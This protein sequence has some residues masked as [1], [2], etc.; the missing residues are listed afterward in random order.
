MLKLWL[1]DLTEPLVPKVLYDDAIAIGKQGPGE[2]PRQLAKFLAKMSTEN[3]RII[4]KLSEFLKRMDVRKTHMNH[5]NLAIVFAPCFLRHDDINVFMANR[6]F[7]M[8]FTRRVIVYAGGED[9]NYTTSSRTTPL[10]TPTP[11]PTPAAAAAAA[12]ASSALT[13]APAVVNGMLQVPVETPEL[14]PF[15]AEAT[16][17]SLNSKLPSS[18]EL[19]R[20]PTTAV[21]TPTLVVLRRERSQSARDAAEQAYAAE[22]EARLAAEVAEELAAAEE[23]AVSDE[24]QQ[25]EALIHTL[26]RSTSRGSRSRNSTLDFDADASAPAAAA[27]THSFAQEMGEQ[28][29]RSFVS[30]CQALLQSG[31]PSYGQAMGIAKKVMQLRKA[32]SLQTQTAELQDAVRSFSL[33][34]ALPLA[35]LSHHVLYWSTAAVDRASCRK[36]L[37]RERCACG[38]WVR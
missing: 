16:K 29:I 19:A 30:D 38:R 17:Q 8:E 3:K 27:A 11:T 23:A 12:A 21:G 5:T 28:E 32:P 14:N 13:P 25:T 1:R 22:H 24:L 2:G 15:A 34:F 7:E 37:S 10:A 35:L 9:L 26:S 33:R 20:V 36:S 4:T 18:T 6:D 31:S